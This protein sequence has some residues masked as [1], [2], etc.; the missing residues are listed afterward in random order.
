MIGHT[1]HIIMWTQNTIGEDLKQ[2]TLNNI[3][4][5]STTRWENEIT[6]INTEEDRSILWANSTFK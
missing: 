3:Q 6:L 2:K 5:G 4:N 1:Y